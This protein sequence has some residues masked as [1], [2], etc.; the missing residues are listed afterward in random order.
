LV[1]PI[2][3][4]SIRFTKKKRT[5]Y[6]K[7]RPTYKVKFNPTSTNP[8]RVSYKSS[9]KKVVGVTSSGKIVPKKRGVATITATTS[10]GK[11]ATMVVRVK[12]FKKF[13][14]RV[15]KS[16]VNVRRKASA[17]SKKMGILKKGK[18][19][20]IRKISKNGQWGM[21]KKNRWIKLSYTN[22]G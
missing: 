19:V 10:N 9:K 22:I 1:K 20:T 17:G 16:R 6:L 3:A 14:A 12:K 4:T 13:K 21:Y 2:K 11:T 18:K 8:K 15:T 5:V 7:T